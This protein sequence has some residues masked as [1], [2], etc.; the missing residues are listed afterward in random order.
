MIKSRKTLIIIILLGLIFILFFYITVFRSETSKPT[1]SPVTT[2]PVIS[3]TTTFIIPPS[4]NPATIAQPSPTPI[5]TATLTREQL[6][7]QTPIETKEFN[8]EYYIESDT[9]R[10][11]IKENPYEENKAKAEQWLQDRGLGPNDLN[12]LW[13]AY[14]GVE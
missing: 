13:A 10:I 11:T 2:I 5:P 7:S 4:L 6:I 9:F 8:I 1:T 14:F 12:I 3:P